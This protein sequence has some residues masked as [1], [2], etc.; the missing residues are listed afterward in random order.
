MGRIVSNF[1]ISLDGVVESPNEF[2]FPY[3]DE[4]VG[5][6]VSAGIEGA[7]AFLLGRVLYQ[8]WSQYWP[9]STDE[10][11]AGFIN[12]I[13]K[14][15]L[16]DTLT[17]ADAVWNPTTVIRGEDVVG[18]VR[19]LKEQIGGPI[20]MSGS[21]TTVRWLATNGLLDELHLLMAPIVVGTGARLFDGARVPLTLVEA[22][23]LPTGVLHLTYRS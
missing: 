16:S 15:V 1:F 8:Q 10:P 3:F 7:K 2:I 19:Q 12:G 20:V 11:F 14:Y 18:Q 23:P 4:A 13:D 5:A 6:V 21:P 22:E 17:E 9:A